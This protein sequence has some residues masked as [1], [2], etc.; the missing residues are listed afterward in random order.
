MEQTS[1]VE[2]QIPDIV[3]P[4]DTFPIFPCIILQFKSNFYPLFAKYA[5]GPAEQ[6]VIFANDEIL[7]ACDLS[8]VISALKQVF[9]IEN[10]VTLEFPKLDISLQ[11]VRVLFCDV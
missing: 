3:S 10:D 11:E 9:G 5:S 7:F 4:P 2:P 6:E 1:T 8:K